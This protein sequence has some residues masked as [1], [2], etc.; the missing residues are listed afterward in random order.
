MVE[1]LVVDDCAT[2]RRLIAGLLTHQP[3]W[4]V[5]EATDGSDALF[6]LANHSVDLVIADLNMPHVDGLALIT[7]VRRTHPA[8]PVVLITGDGSERLAVQALQHGAASYV[9]KASLSESLVETVRQVL[10]AAR[11]DRARMQLFSRM[12]RQEVEFTLDNDND[13]I[14]ALVLF[15]QESSGMQNVCDESGRLRVGVALQEALTNACFH[16]NLELSSDLREVDHRA[17]YEVAEQRRVQEPYRSRKIFVQASF[18]PDE[19]VYVIRDE[20]HG[21]DQSSIPDPTDPRYLERPCGRGLLLMKTF[22]DEVRFN[23]R[24]NE[25]TLIKRRAC[26]PFERGTSS[27]A[28][29]EAPPSIC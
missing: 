20:G 7:A 23:A 8:V 9:S 17:F 3:T 5:T 6:R 29:V 14:A 1:L 16:G 4:R 13:Q 19:V 22:M 24:G 26:D 27:R 15:L 11:E 10:A 12:N 28:L 18:S 2:D 21:F 25:V